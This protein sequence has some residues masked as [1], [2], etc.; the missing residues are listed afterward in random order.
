MR[1]G[2]KIWKDKQM[3]LIVSEKTVRYQLMKNRQR[4]ETYMRN[5]NSG[6]QEEE[7]MTKHEW[8]ASR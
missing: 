6:E 2:E 5:K 4:E 7:G 8:G 3:S 1:K